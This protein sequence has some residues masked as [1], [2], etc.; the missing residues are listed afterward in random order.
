VPENRKGL[1]N[2]GGE[3][4]DGFFKQKNRWT[5]NCGKVN[6][7]LLEKNGKNAKRGKE[8]TNSSFSWRNNGRAIDRSSLKSK[9]GLGGQGTRVDLLNNV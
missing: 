3:K 7:G 1:Y 4:G 8:G 6:G 2:L 5:T 9:G